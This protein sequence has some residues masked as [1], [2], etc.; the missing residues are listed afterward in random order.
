MCQPG[1]PVRGSRESQAAAGPV[2][3]GGSIAGGP[4]RTR[5][6]RAG[7]SGKQIGIERRTLLDRPGVLVG[8][9]AL[10]KVE[11]GSALAAGEVDRRLQRDLAEADAAGPLA[12]VSAEVIPPPGSAGHAVEHGD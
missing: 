2:K 1:S 6:L 3:G 5:Q 7:S 11:L 4:R 10:E 8:V 12:V 9:S